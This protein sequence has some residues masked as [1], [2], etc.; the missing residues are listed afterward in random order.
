MDLQQPKRRLVG[1]FKDKVLDVVRNI[2]KGEVRSYGYVAEAAGNGKASRV[3]GSILRR[4]KDKKVPCHRVIRSDGIVGSY[5]GL[6]GDKE[7]LLRKEG[8]SFAGGKPKVSPQFS[9]N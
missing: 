6:R 8:V 3:V 1:V 9:P 5:N 2:P 4:N 7:R